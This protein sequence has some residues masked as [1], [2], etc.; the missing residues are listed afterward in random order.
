M[1][2]AKRVT[3]LEQL[4]KLTIKATD[5]HGFITC[6]LVLGGGGC[7]GRYELRYYA[8][9]DQPW[10][11]FHGVSG[12]WFSCNDKELDTDTNIIEGIN[13]KALFIF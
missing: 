4:R 12:E 10:D 11:I 2:K 8:D 6:A 13:K 5:K 1:A 3:S 7:F 9:S